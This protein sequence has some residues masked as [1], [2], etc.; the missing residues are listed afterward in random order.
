MKPTA[1]FPGASPVTAVAIVLAL[2]ATLVVGILVLAGVLNGGLA[3]GT[4]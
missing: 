1:W 2:I 4:V 3:A